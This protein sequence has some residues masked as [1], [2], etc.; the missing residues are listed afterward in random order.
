MLHEFTASWQ[1][2]SS[3]MTNVA[4]SYSR[5]MIVVS[6][7]SIS[8]VPMLMVGASPDGSCYR[9][10]VHV[11]TIRGSNSPQCVDKCYHHMLACVAT[12][13]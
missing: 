5:S 10:L 11:A 3:K 6:I 9:K 12:A 2:I 8:T 7:V 13:C 4:K 1:M